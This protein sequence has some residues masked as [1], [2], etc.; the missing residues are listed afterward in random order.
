M[1]APP[2]K[3]VD[4]PKKQKI[5]L[6]HLR[7]SG[8]KD[9]I[10]FRIQPMKKLAFVL[11]LLGGCSLNAATVV[12]T[13][14]NTITS[15]SDISLAGT[16]VHAASYGSGSDVDV[17]VGSETITFGSSTYA[18]GLAT[19]ANSTVTS[20]GVTNQADGFDPAGTTVSVAFE[21][22]LDTFAYDGPNPKVLTLNNLTVGQLYQI[23]LFTADERGCCGARTQLWSDSATLSAG[24]ETSTFALNTSPFDIGTFTAG[25]TSETLYGHGVGQSQTNLNA[26]VLRAVPEPSATLLAALAGLALLRRRR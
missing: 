3:P 25:A 10:P 26:Y 12:W 16:F 18:D 14:H 24:N 13:A 19:S 8:Q 4:F 1:G 6:D 22:V 23:Q 17:V 9:S 11:S 20:A 7:S 21:S 2:I 5:S 15:N